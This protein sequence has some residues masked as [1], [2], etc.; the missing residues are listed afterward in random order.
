M[1]RFTSALS[2]AANRM[3]APLT[4]SRELVAGAPG[5]AVPAVHV[6]RGADPT[7]IAMQRSI[8]TISTSSQA[9]VTGLIRAGEPSSL[10]LK[11]SGD[12]GALQRYHG[13][14]A[15]GN[16][17]SI[18]PGFGSTLPGTSTV[19]GQPANPMLALL[20]ANESNRAIATGAT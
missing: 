5:N 19:P 1:G 12:L 20:I 7:A 15:V 17:T 3:P 9:G 10:G 14:A 11:Y 4:P 8:D 18:R 2:A 13:A 6:L 16:R